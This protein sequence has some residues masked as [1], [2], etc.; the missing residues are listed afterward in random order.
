MARG[1]KIL[2]L[3][4]DGVLNGER[5]VQHPTEPYTDLDE[6][7]V[8]RLVPL[9]DAHPDLHI[10]LSTAWRLLQGVDACVEAL[11]R[12]GLLA[13]PRL[14]IGATP[15]LTDQPWSWAMMAPKTREAEIA[16]FLD[17]FPDPIQ[18]YAIVDDMKMAPRPDGW[19]F[20]RTPRDGIRETHV[21]R[22]HKI[23]STP[24]GEPCP[25]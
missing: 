3:D 19:R 8:A 23:L 10:V 15:D 13:A 11:V 20:V 6:R 4:F 18:S 7:H 17:A 16:K 5:F 24:L 14:V 12:R 25:F 1:V 21:R 2:F 22:L 9:F